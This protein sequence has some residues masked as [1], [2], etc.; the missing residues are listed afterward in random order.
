MRGYN[1]FGDEMKAHFGHKVYKLSLESGF[2]CPVRDGSKGTEGCYYC[3]DTGAHYVRPH[4]DTSA[5]WSIKAQV[6]HGKEFLYTWYQAK[7]FIAYFQSHTSTYGDIAMLKQMLADSIE[8]PDVVG[9]SLST[10][11]DCLS[12]DIL[13]VLGEFMLDKY[14]WLEL[15]LETSHNSTL[16]AVGRGHTYED[17]LDA[18]ARAKARGFRI[19]VHVIL[20]L[21]GETEEMMMET[22]DRIIDLKVDG[23]KF[24]HLHILKNSVFEKWYAD[25]KIKLF[26]KEEYFDL[27]LKILKKLPKN[28]VI[29]RLFGDAPKDLLIAPTWILNKGEV[30]RDFDRLVGN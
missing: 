28:I 23:V 6:R 3:G 30:L 17:F 7:K 21:P 5:D 2:T 12:D 10:R 16:N 22:I 25:G 4:Y 29:H 9:L 13:D 14:H 27:L 19:C 15:G 8:D 18:Y 26:T 1:Y 20:G 24:H 11:P